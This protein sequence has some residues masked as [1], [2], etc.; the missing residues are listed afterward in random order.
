M[1]QESGR[2]GGIVFGILGL[3]SIAMLVY[4]MEFT[5]MYSTGP[6]KSFYEFVNR[7]IGW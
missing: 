3:V 4:M 6:T 7:T 2:N 1:P 5:S